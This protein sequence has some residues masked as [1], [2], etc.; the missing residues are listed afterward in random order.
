MGVDVDDQKKK[1]RNYG[2]TVRR[3]DLSM[4]LLAM[5]RFEYVQPVV[6]FS[7]TRIVQGPFLRDGG[8]S[9]HLLDGCTPTP[10]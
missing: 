4:M 7:C 6:S 3:H 2:G 8:V 5:G 10:A 1:A 9:D